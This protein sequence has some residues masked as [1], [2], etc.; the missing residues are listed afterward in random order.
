M[1]YVYKYYALFVWYYVVI[2]GRVA[3]RHHVLEQKRDA[4][5]EQEKARM[6]KDKER[7]M[8]LEKTKIPVNLTEYP[9]GNLLADTYVMNERVKMS[10]FLVKRLIH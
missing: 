4:M 8:L 1:L 7:K 9:V 2:R 5:K 6:E 10:S 3:H